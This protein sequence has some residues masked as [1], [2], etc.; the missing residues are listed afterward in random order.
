MSELSENTWLVEQRGVA[1]AYLEVRGIPAFEVGET[2]A[3]HM[4]PRFALWAVRSR[5][6]PTS[7]AWWVAT[8]DVP[9][10]S[11]SSDE[12]KTPRAAVAGF[13]RRWGDASIQMR[14]G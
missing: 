8:G 14:N 2:P 4:P 9:T 7:A 13:S 1:T 10:D 11:L 12:G 3:F 5:R 6:E